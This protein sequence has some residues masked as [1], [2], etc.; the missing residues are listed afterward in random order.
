MGHIVN[1]FLAFENFLYCFLELTV[2]VCN[3]VNVD[4]FPASLLAFVVT[5]FLGFSYFD[6]GKIKF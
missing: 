1:L 6:W 3:L 5:C 2:P 4:S